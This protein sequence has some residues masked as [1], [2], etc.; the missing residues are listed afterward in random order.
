MLGGKNMGRLGHSSAEKG[1]SLL[2]I[3]DAE[4]VRTEVAGYL[5]LFA[6]EVA[7]A[8][9]GAEGIRKFNEFHPD[10]VITDIRMAGMDGIQVTREI[11]RLSERT[12][13]I[14]T[15][16]YNEIAYREQLKELGVKDI[17]VKPFLLD[18]LKDVVFKYFPVN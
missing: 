12:P 4:D 14:V 18:R 3:E 6:R 2:Y 11:H 15:T 13:V 1:F 10:L 17:L 8:G 7:E 5:R 9:S 16:A